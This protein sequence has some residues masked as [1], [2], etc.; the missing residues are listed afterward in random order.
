MVT[1]IAYFYAGNKTIFLQYTKSFYTIRKFF[2]SLWFIPLNTGEIPI[3]EVT[4][5]IMRH[6]FQKW[7]LGLTIL[8]LLIGFFFVQEVRIQSAISAASADP[9]AEVLVS[10]I[11]NLETETASLE[12]RLSVIRQETENLISQSTNGKSQLTDL[13]KQLTQ[14]QISAGIT[15]LE[16]PG[17]TVT[18]DDN[19]AGL[20][21]APNDDP[22]RYVIHYENLLYLVN[23]L[24]NAGAEGISINGQRIVVSSEIRCVGNVILVNT[25]RLAPPFEISVIGNPTSLENAISNSTTYQQL[26]LSGF[27]VGYKIF[28][29]HKAITLPAY[30]GSFSTKILTS[31]VNEEDH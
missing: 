3:E 12:E 24:R 4:L 15:S 14:Q 31:V 9:K 30:T 16:G 29:G 22:N 19:N 28:T 17:I 13:Q 5:V 27:P 21:A 1:I 7:T 25:T 6:F 18:L 26:S 10:L 2:P 20:S 11:T 23:D 8:F